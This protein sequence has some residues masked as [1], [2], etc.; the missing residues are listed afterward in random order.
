[1]SKK[2]KTGVFGVGSLGQWHA[3]IY[4]E[5]ETVDL[6]GVHDVNHDRAKEIADRYNTRAFDTVDELAK[7][8]EAASVVVPTDKHIEVFNCL[9]GH[10]LHMLMEK[11][12]AATTAEAEEM[13]NTAKD[14]E[15][16]LQVGHVERFNPVI[17]FLDEQLTSP[18]F[19]EAIRLAPYPP[20]R[21]G[22]KPRGTEVSVVL[23]L[24]IH[25]LDIILHLVRSPVTS[26]SATGVS[27]LSVTE[28]I[29]NVR[30]SFAN[31][32]VANVTASRISREQMRK[33]RVFQEDTYLSLDYMNQEGLLCRK[34]ETGIETIPVP[35]DKN[36]PLA[37]ELSSFVDCVLTKDDPIVNGEHG[38]EALK[39]AVE[40]CRI[41]REDP[42]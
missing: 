12:I 21:E 10:G 31:K 34:S 32:C 33:I 7:S 24:M 26:I 8:I 22:N 20:P 25:D 39:I 1:M 3:R 40:I 38:S 16:I 35:I 37:V 23:D 15:I 27:V 17:G 6:V 36:E 11:P 18:R 13:V 41:I 28:D 9:A 19:I 4:S 42:S 29:A 2:L 14:K 30:I 5:L